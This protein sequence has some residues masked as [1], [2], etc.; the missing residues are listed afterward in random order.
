[1]CKDTGN[2]YVVSS[3]P[4]QSATGVP[5]GA[6]MEFV[7]NEDMNQVAT[8][9]AYQS[10]SS[11]ITANKVTLRWPNARTLRVEPF[12]P[13]NCSFGNTINTPARS[14]VATITTAATDLAGNSLASEYTLEFTTCRTVETK[15]VASTLY[16]GTAWSDNN[17]DYVNPGVGDEPQNIERRTIVGF[18]ISDI[19]SGASIDSATLRLLRSETVIGDP[20]TNLGSLYVGQIQPGVMSSSTFSSTQI[21]AESTLQTIVDQSVDVSTA[22][23]DS[24]PLAGDRRNILQYR[25]RFGT[26]TNAD[27]IADVILPIISVSDASAG[28]YLQVKFTAP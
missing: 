22:L 5:L 10:A 23:R 14:Y 3:S 2:P 7:F 28:C 26:P 8:Q 25:M 1:M 27:G 20:F 4:I 24:L 9:N 6:Y 17:Y 11:G 15:L 18:S 12:S 21:G 19:P 13:L 16:S